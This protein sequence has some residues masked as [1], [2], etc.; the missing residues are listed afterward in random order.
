M[1][2]KNLLFGD[3]AKIRNG[4]A[5]KSKDLQN[6]DIP[7]IKIKNIVS[8][9]VDINDTQKVSIDTY[10]KNNRFTLY[11]GDILIS[12]TGSGVNQM[13][14]AVGK[15]G[16]IE[17]DQLTLQ[18]QRV[19]KFELINDNVADLDFLYYFFL[20]SSVTEYLVRNSTGSANQANINPK[21]IESVKIPNFTL[22][23]QKKIS[24]LLNI[25]SMKIQINNQIIAKLEELSQTLFKRWFIDFEFPDENGNPYKSSGGEMVKS[26]S[27]LIP[28]NWK[29]ATLDSIAEFTNG[30]AMQKYMLNDETESLPVV[31]IKELKNG[32]VDANSAICTLN[33]PDKAKIFDGDIIFSWSATLL[34]DMWAGGNAGLNQHLYKVTSKNYEKWFYYFWIKYHLRNFISIASDKATTMGHIN[35]KHLTEAKV[36]IPDEDSLKIFNTEMK[37]YFEEMLNISLQNKNL[38]ELRDTLLPKLMSGEVELPN[39]LEVEEHAKLLQ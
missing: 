17:F 3:V 36:L 35:R 26:E 23:Q 21:L 18:N 25:L 15:V 13:T 32:Y 9:I 10:E 28:F 37:V 16:R 31:K 38:M 30:L 39:D 1:E 4:F 29:V 19:G 5:F 22:D 33:I 11:K 12:L 20:Q 8:P 34:V 27:E 14:S 24:K 7:V 6:N 2:S